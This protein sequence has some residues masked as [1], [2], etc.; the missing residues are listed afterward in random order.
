MTRQILLLVGACVS[1]A[2]ALADDTVTFVTV[3]SGA[4][5]EIG[6]YS[7]QRATLS[8]ERPTT[9]TKVPDGLVAPQYGV[10]PLKSAEGV[11]FHVVLDEPDGQPAKLFVDSNGN[12]D[13]TDDAG[14][15]WAGQARK[16]QDGKESTMYLGGA[17]LKLGAAGQPFDAHLSMY[18]FDRNDPDRAALKDVILYYR[19]YATAGELKLGNKSYKA[20]LTDENA[21]GDFRGVEP[22]VDAKGN[23]KGSGVRLLIDVNANGKFENRGEGYDVRD[24]FNIAGVV[25]ELR[26]VSADGTTFKL[27]RS[28]KKVAEILPPPD[29]SV[30][31][32]ITAF[33]GKTMGGK[34]VK[35]P[36]SYKGKIVLLDF[37]ATW[38]GPCMAEMPNVA[39]AYEKFHS[40]GFEILGISLD[41]KDAEDKIRKV[42]EDQNMPWPQVYDGGYWKAAI[43]QL[44]VVNSIPAAYLVDGDTGEVLADNR[45]LR[46]EKLS[47]TIEKALEKKQK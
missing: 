44:Y 28:D 19:D 39:A 13:L 1:P 18:R 20:M 25:W 11:V 37:W 15:E 22:V 29:H 47:E 6:Y 41:Q 8:A 30:G 21:T 27:A 23:S 5:K 17:T 2:V 4:M 43:A 31:K 12:G 35:F 14:A 33:E 38:C 26:D 16:G 10:L 46:G 3:S 24:A 34:D 7:P 36:S 32:V 45:G 40:R 42:A 9:I